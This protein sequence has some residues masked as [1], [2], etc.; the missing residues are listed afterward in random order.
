MTSRA[1][2]RAGYGR[3]KATGMPYV[4]LRCENCRALVGM[5]RHVANCIESVLKS[6]WAARVAQLRS[7]KCR[8]YV[9]QCYKSSALRGYRLTTVLRIRQWRCVLIGCFCSKNS[10]FLF[11]IISKSDVPQPPLCPQ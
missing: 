2:S 3:G 6:R 1:V 10:I 5:L 4:L 9:L 7:T 11:I 8:H